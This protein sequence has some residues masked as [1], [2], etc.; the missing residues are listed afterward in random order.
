MKGIAHFSIGVAAATFIPGVMQNALTGHSF[1]LLVAGAFGLLPDTLDFKVAR[2][3]D[4]EDYVIDPNPDDPNPQKMAE[5]VARAINDAYESNKEIRVRFH[6]MQLAPDRWRKYEISFDTKNSEV[7]IKIGPIVSTSQQPFGGTEIHGEKAIGRAKVKCGIIHMH[8]APSRVDILSG[9][10]IGFKPRKNGKVEVI[11]IPWHRQWSHSFT[12][13]LYMGLAVFLIMGLINGWSSGLYWASL[14]AIPFWAHVA[15]DCLGF[16][17]GNLLWPFT[18]E[19]TP[20]LKFF[21]A[22]EALANFSGVW[23]SGLVIVYN[24]NRIA[25]EPQFTMGPIKFFA[26]WLGI[27]ALVVALYLLIDKKRKNITAEQE[28][29]RE[30]L[31]EVADGGAL[32][33]G[34]IK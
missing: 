33:G 16:M 7:M 26:I 18:K 1:D 29:T 11:F 31:D 3:F 2:F 32:G 12:L 21:H 19:R 22:S 25:P 34:R 8:D 5:T 23:I 17:G 20:G 27:P 4:R 30:L 13:G 14:V 15:A 28:Q 6:T 24:A 9:P 10:T